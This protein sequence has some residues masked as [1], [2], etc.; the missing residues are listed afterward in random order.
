MTHQE[1]PTLTMYDNE[2]HLNIEA[3][4][5]ELVRVIRGNGPREGELM[6][7]ARVTP[8]PDGGLEIDFTPAP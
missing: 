3:R 8:T 5:G 2:A 4:G 6:G 7:W 1:I